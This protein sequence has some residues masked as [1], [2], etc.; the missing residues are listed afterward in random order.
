MSARSSQA[1]SS[2]CGADPRR[3]L[4]PI[5]QLACLAVVAVLLPLIV[6]PPRKAGTAPPLSPTDSAPPVDKG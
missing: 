6:R 2:A 1:R 3:R 5:A 4:R